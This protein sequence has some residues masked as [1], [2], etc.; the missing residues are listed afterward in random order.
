M[1]GGGA[2]VPATAWRM[3]LP[4]VLPA[5]SVLPGSVRDGKSREQDDGPF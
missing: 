3:P 5:D 4:T 2:V 1:A